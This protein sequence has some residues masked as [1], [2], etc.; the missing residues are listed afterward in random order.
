MIN[1][2]KLSNLS[3]ELW[4]GITK[5]DLITYLLYVGPILTTYLQNLPLSLLRAPNGLAGTAFFQKNMPKSSPETLK[6]W[7]FTRHERKT[8]YLLL[9]SPSD[10]VYLGNLACIELHSWLSTYQCWNK[11]QEIVIDL[12]PNPDV[13][14]R[15]WQQSAFKIK[16]L[17]D[18]LRLKS[19]P[20]VTGRKGLHIMIPLIPNY[21]YEELA[22]FFKAIR[23]LVINRW[24]D[25]FTGELYK[26]KRQ[27]P[28]Y[29]DLRQNGLEKTVIAPYS[30]RL[31]DGANVAVP[32]K[33]ETL[34]SLQEKPQWSV[35]QKK[36]PPLYS[37]P[38]YNQSLPLTFLG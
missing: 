30:P 33:W 16:D 25:L 37:P 15:I 5:Q 31:V 1:S 17:L 24:P 28:I 14:F 23:E 12:D 26:E 29:L 38:R 10:L 8:R 11:P 27:A 20:K 19:Y 4:P 7:V 36:W 13:N 9:N 35:L 32:I 6:T 3:K 34:Y 21:S 22:P 18:K 2:Y